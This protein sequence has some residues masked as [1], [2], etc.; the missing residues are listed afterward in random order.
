[1][2]YESLCV[3][4]VHVCQYLTSVSPVDQAHFFPVQQ[5][6]FLPL[7]LSTDVAQLPLYPAKTAMH[8]MTSW[9]YKAVA[10]EMHSAQ[11][12]FW[13]AHHSVNSW[14]RAEFIS[15]CLTVSSISSFSSRATNGHQPLTLFCLKIEMVGSSCSFR[16]MS[17]EHCFAVLAPRGKRLRS[18][19]IAPGSRDSQSR[20]LGIVYHPYQK[21]SRVNRF[22]L[23][24][25]PKNTKYILT[26]T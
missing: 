16:I 19:S 6:F 1:M 12:H 15:V 18:S 22:A 24:M 7:L 11:L 21:P 26:E 9:R 5:D 4:S 23:L 17:R 14:E 8:L 10:V 20:Q 25:R 13:A 3:L 2:I